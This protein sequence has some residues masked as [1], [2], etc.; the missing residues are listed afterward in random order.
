MSPRIVF[1]IFAIWVLF[2]IAG[3]GNE[4][5]SESLASPELGE[6]GGHVCSM[7]RLFAF[8]IFVIYIF[9]SLLDLPLY[10]R[11]DL[12]FIGIFWFTLTFA[13]EIVHRHYFKRYSW[14]AVLEN[15]NIMEGGIKG[16]V[17]LAELIAPYLFWVR[18]QFIDRGALWNE[19]DRIS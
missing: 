4:K 2:I 18:R 6:Y 1:Y 5:I 8:V 7:L 9:V 14:D 11:A 15:Y 3:V 19:N 16:F 12:L 17:L 13:L 10:N